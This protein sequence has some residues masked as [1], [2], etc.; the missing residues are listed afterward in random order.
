MTTALYEGQVPVFTQG[1]RLRKARETTGKGVR[2]FALLIGVSHQTITNAEH[3]HRN[4]RPITMN[5]WAM[6]TGV[7]IQWLKTGIAPDPNGGAEG[8][9][10]PPPGLE[11]EPSGSQPPQVTRLREWPKSPATIQRA[12]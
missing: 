5:A 4:V 10:A 3:E 8:N 9:H 7:S 1:D 12:A 2:E 6:A 11:P